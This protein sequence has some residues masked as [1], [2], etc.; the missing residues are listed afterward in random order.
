MR[1][2]HKRMCI[3]ICLPCSTESSPHRQGFGVIRPH[4]DLNQD[5]GEGVC[6]CDVAQAL[7]N[8]VRLSG[9]CHPVSKCSAPK[10]A[11]VLVRHCACMQ[12]LESGFLP[13]HTCIEAHTHMQSHTNRHRHAYTYTRAHAHTHT[14]TH[15]HTQMHTH[16]HTHT[17]THTHTHKIHSMC[18]LPCCHPH[19][20]SVC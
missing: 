14:H 9:S 5:V 8:P 3:R 15:T 1:A 16:P 13:I 11:V 10:G 2:L 4:R 20:G 17:H 18:C 12:T 19:Y 7:E 6:K